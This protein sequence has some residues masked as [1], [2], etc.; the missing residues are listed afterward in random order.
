MG[1]LGLESMKEQLRD[2]SIQSQILK[3][4]NMGCAL[5]VEFLPMALGLKFMTRS[6]RKRDRDYIALK[7]DITCFLRE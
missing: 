2:D 3:L 7:D 4:S 1:F 5:S 6:W